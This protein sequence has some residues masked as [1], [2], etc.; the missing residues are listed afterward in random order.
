MKGAFTGAWKDQPGPARGRARRHRV[1]RRGRRAAARAAGQA[2]ALPRGAALRA[3]RRRRRR[4]RW[5]SA[6]SPRPIATSRPRC[7]PAGSGRTC[8]SASG[9]RLALPAAARASARTCRRWSTTCSAPLCA[10]HRR[11]LLAL[12]PAARAALLA[13]DWPGNVRELVNALERA[14]VLARG[15]TIRAE[16]L[17]DHL[18]APAPASRPCRAAPR[19]RTWSG[20]TCARCSPSPRPWR[21]PPLASASTSRPSGGSASAGASTERRRSAATGLTGRRAR[22]HR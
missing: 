11:P 20:A 17:P 22:R 15:E 18:L 16:D 5:T 14:L 8:S 7:A 19:S 3:R 9:D 12:D 2:A 1:P 10:R 21:K 6:S 13:Y 4:A